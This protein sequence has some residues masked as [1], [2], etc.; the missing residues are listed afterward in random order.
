MSPCSLPWPEPA[1]C[2]ALV[3]SVLWKPRIRWVVRELHLLASLRYTRLPC[4]VTAPPLG[5][6]QGGDGGALGVAQAERLDYDWDWIALE[7]A[8]PAEAVKHQHALA[9]PVAAHVEAGAEVGECVLARGPG[10]VRRDARVV[11]V[12]VA[13]VKDQVEPEGARATGV[14]V[15]EHDGV[16]VAGALQV[17]VR[18]A[19][20]RGAAARLGGM[21]I[22]CSTIFRH[23]LVGE[24][25]AALVALLL[26]QPLEVSTI[27]ARHRFCTLEQTAGVLPLTLRRSGR[28]INHHALTPRRFV[29]CRAR[30]HRGNGSK[31]TTGPSQA[32][33]ETCSSIALWKSSWYAHFGK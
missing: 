33:D 22:H 20:P 12:M 21:R 16:G 7:G 26:D 9:Q 27:N 19:V 5:L 25:V 18:D 23:I 15:L 31:A 29:E 1:A 24:D 30:I 3:E 17:A 11:G 28:A 4:P 8:Q 14:R 6:V 10:L 13:V 2:R 32:M